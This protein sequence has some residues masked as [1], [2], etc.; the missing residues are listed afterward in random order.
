VGRNRRYI[1][2]QQA[3]RQRES[4]PSARIELLDGLG[5]WSFQ[6]DPARVAEAV[7]PFLLEQAAEG[8]ELGEPEPACGPAGREPD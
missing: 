3:E 6:E 7:M 1:P 2:W 8:S 4:F 5:H